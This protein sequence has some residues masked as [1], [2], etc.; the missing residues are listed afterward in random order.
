MIRFACSS[1]KSV[2]EAPESKAGAAVSCPRCKKPLRIPAAAG[3]KAGATP[4]KPASV[5]P[6]VAVPVAV[7]ATAPSTSPAGTL[8][9]KANPKLLAL[10]AGG[11]V[12]L[13]ALVIAVRMF[14]SG[15]TKKTSRPLNELGEVAQAPIRSAK[16]APVESSGPDIVDDLASPEFDTRYRAALAL[17]KQDKISKAA[18]K[19]L[20]AL[21]QDRTDTN[22]AVMLRKIAARSLGKIGPEAKSAIEPLRIA[23]GDPNLEVRF[24]AVEALGKMGPDGIPPIVDTLGDAKLQVKSCEV[25]SRYGTEAGS[26]VATMVEVMRNVDVDVR[27]QVASY[28]VKV[29]RANTAVLPVLTKGLKDSND[30][31]RRTA[32]LALGTMGPNAKSAENELYDVATMDLNEDIKDLANDAYRKIGGGK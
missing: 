31:I 4:A 3:G 19:P 25:L 17:D 20:I 32:V 28:I 26:A 29:D 18:I 1:C 13:L 2:M 16:E 7:S 23:L 21:L 11:I 15:G 8:L 30:T 9:Q 27:V 14:S 12:L 5:V 6:V 24:V 10:G 22:S